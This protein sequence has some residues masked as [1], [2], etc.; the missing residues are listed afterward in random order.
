VEAVL[1]TPQQVTGNHRDAAK[2]LKV[3][4]VRTKRVE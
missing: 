4:V 1:A 2:R 3:P